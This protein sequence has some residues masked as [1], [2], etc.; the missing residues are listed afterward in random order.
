MLARSC[1]VAGSGGGGPH[2]AGRRKEAKGR[3]IFALCVAFD[4]KWVMCLPTL[5]EDDFALCITYFGYGFCFANL[6]GDN[7]IT[8]YLGPC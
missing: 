5:L 2:V 8:E 7:L 1:R 4:P 3:R 6:V